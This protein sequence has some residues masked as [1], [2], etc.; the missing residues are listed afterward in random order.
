[1]KSIA[2]GEV[3]CDTKAGLGDMPTERV[4]AIRRE[5][6]HQPSVQGPRHFLVFVD[7]T[8]RPGPGQQPPQARGAL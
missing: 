8:L 3:R 7:G 2:G 1:M 6:K 4:A 5:Q